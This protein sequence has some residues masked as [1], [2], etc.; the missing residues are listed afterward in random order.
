[1]KGI[2]KLFRCESSPSYEF[3]VPSVEVTEAPDSDGVDLLKKKQFSFDKSDPPAFVNKDTGSPVL[4]RRQYSRQ[5]RNSNIR[6]YRTGL[7]YQELSSLYENELDS[8]IEK[9]ASLPRTVSY[10][11]ESPIVRKLSCNRLLFIPQTDIRPSCRI[12]CQEQPSCYATP[13]PSFNGNQYGNEYCDNNNSKNN[14][15]HKQYNTSLRSQSWETVTANTNSGLIQNFGLKVSSNVSAT[16]RD[17]HHTK[18]EAMSE[19]NKACCNNT[20]K[21]QLKANGRKYSSLEDNVC[22]NDVGNYAPVRHRAV[23]QALSLGCVGHC[24]GCSYPRIV[25]S[26]FGDYFGSRCQLSTYAFTSSSHCCIG[27]GEERISHCDCAV[28]NIRS[29]SSETILDENICAL[30]CPERCSG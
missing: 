19:V 14:L 18:D 10:R 1:M 28:S 20:D 21:Q 22:D 4:L 27:C 2:K 13:V 30:H 5:Q 9:R 3:I 12:H 17:T 25:R 23:H 7:S 26:R 24:S 29:K 16:K 8:S 11:S 15:L 6:K